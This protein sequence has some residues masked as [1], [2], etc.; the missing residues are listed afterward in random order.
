MQELR[1]AF[2][3]RMRP[4]ICL[5]RHRK[6]AYNTDTS[7]TAALYSNAALKSTEIVNC[8]DETF[9]CDASSYVDTHM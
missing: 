8:M 3:L 7:G 2:H 5:L 4:C 1:S 9:A 6:I